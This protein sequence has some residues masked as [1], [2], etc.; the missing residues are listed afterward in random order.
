MDK[1]FMTCPGPKIKNNLDSKN[2]W[3]EALEG[4]RPRVTVGHREV[5]RM[6]MPPCWG[7]T[8]LQLV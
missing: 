1:T 4:R 5:Y 2:P 8:C 6:W 7:S 3:Q